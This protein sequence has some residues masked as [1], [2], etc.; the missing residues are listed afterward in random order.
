MVVL[1]PNSFGNLLTVCVRKKLSPSIYSDLLS[2]FRQALEKRFSV[3][4]QLIAVSSSIQPFAHFFLLVLKLANFFLCSCENRSRKKA[5]IEF[6]QQG[7]TQS[8]KL[9]LRHR[10]YPLGNRFG[11]RFWRVVFK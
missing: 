2:C 9:T 3:E 8:A 10:R 5:W 1:Q 4:F 11:A 6:H 7:G